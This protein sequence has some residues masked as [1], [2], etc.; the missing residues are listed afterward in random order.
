MKFNVN[1]P[2]EGMQLKE[3]F[4]VSRVD[5]ICYPRMYSEAVRVYETW[6]DFW[7]CEEPDKYGPIEYMEGVMAS[8]YIP[9]SVH[10]YPGTYV[11]LCV[12]RVYAQF[13]K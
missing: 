2:A 3:L 11:K 7:D 12:D 10:E 8:R 13:R 5:I 6:E 1:T 9:M 4:V